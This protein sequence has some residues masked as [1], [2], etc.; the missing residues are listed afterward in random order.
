M[1]GSL[2]AK[3]IDRENADAQQAKYKRTGQSDA[4]VNLATATKPR[5]KE[6][7]TSES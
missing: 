2:S 5:R 3:L 7:S 4:Y 1:N 6:R